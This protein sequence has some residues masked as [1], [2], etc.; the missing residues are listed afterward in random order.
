MVWLVQSA[1][2]WFSNICTASPCS[3]ITL[4]LKSHSS[5]WWGI[6]HLTYGYD[7]C[8]LS[9]LSCYF[10][11][12]QVNWTHTKWCARIRDERAATRN[13]AHIT[14]SEKVTY[15]VFQCSCGHSVLNNT[16]MDTF[17][18]SKQLY[19]LWRSFPESFKKSY[20]FLFDFANG[21]NMARNTILHVF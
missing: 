8:V 14:F 11:A 5:S 17:V 20:I 4:Q 12:I 7:L 15:W 10:A 2:Y 6:L 16:L 9:S 19:A 1:R 21:L 3:H 18:S 13:T